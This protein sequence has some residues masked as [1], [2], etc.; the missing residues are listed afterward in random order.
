MKFF[1]V[2]LMQWRKQ[3][4]T[5]NKRSFWWKK[6][7]WRSAR[8]SASWNCTQRADEL[9]QCSTNKRN[10]PAS[11][12]VQPFCCTIQFSQLR[13][14]FNSHAPVGHETDLQILWHF[15]MPQLKSIV[16]GNDT[17]RRKG[18]EEDEARTENWGCGGGL[19]W[20]SFP[21]YRFN[22]L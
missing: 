7:K 17:S 19:G 6:I 14:Y 21:V 3:S 13:S 5:K 4:E 2:S 9:C 1:Q 15:Q 18:A 11:F 10:A 16:N 22:R 20:G 8:N 12:F